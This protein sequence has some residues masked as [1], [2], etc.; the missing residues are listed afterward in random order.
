MRILFIL[1]VVLVCTSALAQSCT[2]F[3]NSITCDNGLSA[4]RSGSTTTWSDGTHSTTSGNTTIWS[5]G[6]SVNRSGRSG[7]YSNGITSNTFGNTTK[8]SNGLVCTR[9]ANTVACSNDGTHPAI[10]QTDTNLILR[11]LMSDV[12]PTTP[13]SP[14]DAKAPNSQSAP[15]SGQ[16]SAVPPK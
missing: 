4:N 2:T 14:A 9:F 16:N 15:S 6:T 11:T 1:I 8:F 3:A 13:T 10:S 12:M 7:Q 5:D